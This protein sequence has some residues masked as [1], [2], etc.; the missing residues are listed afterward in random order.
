MWLL[1]RGGEERGRVAASGVLLLPSP[2]P[3]PLPEREEAAGHAGGQAVPLHLR[4]LPLAAAGELEQTPPAVVGREGGR[5][6]G[7]RGGGGEVHREGNT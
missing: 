4:P 6:G 3:P 2:L 7:R 5:E 1:R